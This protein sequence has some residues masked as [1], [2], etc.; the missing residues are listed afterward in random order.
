M[1]KL[2]K[3]K[4]CECGCGGF[5][6]KARNGKYNEFIRGHNSKSSDKTDHLWKKGES[7]NK[8]GRPEG[9][10][11][12]VT[13]ASLNLLENEEQVLTRRAIDSAM[14]GNTQMLK[15]CLERL[16]PVKKSLPVNLP[17][18]PEVNSVSDAHKTTAY[19]IQKMTDG[20]ISPTDAEV[21]SRS[22]ERHLRAL[23]ISD[24]EA[25]LAELEE[26]IGS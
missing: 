9:S 2:Q 3:K 6:E 5:T 18:M 26:K 15:F 25:R 23:Q 7:G 4:R 17:D 14:S 13:I 12:K 16:V 24:L 11:N 1:K 19:L 20:T 21:I 22:C 8:K 10:K